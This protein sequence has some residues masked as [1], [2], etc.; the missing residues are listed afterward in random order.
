MLYIGLFNFMCLTMIIQALYSF[1]IVTD[2]ILSNPGDVDY[3]KKRTQQMRRYNISFA[4]PK[5]S[6]FLL[7]DEILI[8][9]YFLAV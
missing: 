6:K 5:N 9:I 3:R 2:A 7:P 4:Y 8:W 1:P